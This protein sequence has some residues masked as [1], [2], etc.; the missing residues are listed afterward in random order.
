[1]LPAGTE[2]EKQ[3]KMDFTIA[4]TGSWLTALFPKTAL[5]NDLCEWGIFHINTAT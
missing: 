5:V 3:L 4:I 2:K 1:M